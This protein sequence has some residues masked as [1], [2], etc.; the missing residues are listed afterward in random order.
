MGF[1]GAAAPREKSYSRS[2]SALLKI[3]RYKYLFKPAA[4]GFFHYLVGFFHY[5]AEKKEETNPHG[6]KGARRARE[7]FL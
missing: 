1:R 5:L 3:N 7:G 4:V 6:G 2:A